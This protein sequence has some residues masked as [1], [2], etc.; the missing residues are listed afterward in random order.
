MC[1]DQVV[2]LFY[3]YST[4]MFQVY[5][6][7]GHLKYVYFPLL[8]MNHVDLTDTT[9]DTHEY[10]LVNQRLFFRYL[11]TNQLTDKQDF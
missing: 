9:S 6:L 10:E 3:T 7:R 8:G 1:G 5:G 11:Q 4:K 2:V